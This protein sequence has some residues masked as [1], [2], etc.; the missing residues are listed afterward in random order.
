L[1]HSIDSLKEA[2]EIVEKQIKIGILTDP[3]NLYLQLP[4]I[5]E[6]I[7]ELIEIRK[8]GNSHVDTKTLS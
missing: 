8:K 4:T 2:L 3:I 5:K 7:M 1:P 6:A